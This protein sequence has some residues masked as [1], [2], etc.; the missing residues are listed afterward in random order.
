MYSIKSVSTVAFDQHGSSSFPSITGGC[1]VF[2]A[3]KVRAGS[4]ADAKGAYN[5]RIINDGAM[6]DAVESFIFSSNLSVK[7]HSGVA[8][9]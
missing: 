6:I 2:A 4:R 8:V 7:P 9:F 3:S 5:K 1:V